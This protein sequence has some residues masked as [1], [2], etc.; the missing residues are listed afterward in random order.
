MGGGEGGAL[1]RV[2]FFAAEVES[3]VDVA[4][5]FFFFFSF[6]VGEIIPMTLSKG[7]R[8]GVLMPISSN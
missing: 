5:F 1:F 7:T 2:S 3:F 6:V 8:K 4:F